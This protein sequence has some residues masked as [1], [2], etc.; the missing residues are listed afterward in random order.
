[1]KKVFPMVSKKQEAAQNKV[2]ATEFLQDFFQDLRSKVARNDRELEEAAE[3]LAGHWTNYCV[4]YE[5]LP[6]IDRELVVKTLRKTKGAPGLDGWSKADMKAISHAP[7]VISSLMGQF[8][9]WSTAGTAPTQLRHC[10]LT[11]LPKD[12]GVQAQSLPSYNGPVN[13]L[14]SVV[15]CLD[16]LPPGRPISSNF[17]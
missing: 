13:V 17:P 11:Y 5:R 7:L 14:E 6:G 2:Q 12:E 15:K 8:D 3:Q 4:D 16:C 10:K 9:A 1:M